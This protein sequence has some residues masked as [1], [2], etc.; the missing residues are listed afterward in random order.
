M[1]K[2]IYLLIVL[3]L[4][5]NCNSAY[6]YNDEVHRRLN[7]N[8]SN[9]NNSNLNSVLKSEL[10]ILKGIEQPLKKGNRI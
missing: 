3:L 4:V 5:M 9:P 10:G 8:A 1:P 2:K 6:S 7:I